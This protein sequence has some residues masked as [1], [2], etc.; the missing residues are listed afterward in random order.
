MIYK[1]SP[2]FKV[3]VDSQLEIS[4]ESLYK[5]FAFKNLNPEVTN[6]VTRLIDGAEEDSL[7]DLLLHNFGLLS[8]FYFYFEEFKKLG[9]LSI[10]VGTLDKVLVE[11]TPHTPD[12]CY[13]KNAFQQDQKFKLSRFCFFRSEGDHFILETPLCPVHIK[14]V[15][16]DALTIIYSFASPKSMI[17]VIQGNLN[18]APKIVEDLCQLLYQA[19]I[20]LTWDDHT[21]EEKDPHFIPWEFHD[22][23]FHSRSRKGRHSYAFGGTYPHQNSLPSPPAIKKTS[24]QIIVPLKIPDFEEA[25]KNSLP[26][27]FVLENRRSKR[28]GTH[29]LSS[30]EIS[31]FL[32]KSCRV[33]SIQ[34]TAMGEITVRPYPSAGGRYELEIYLVIH[35]CLEIPSGLYYYHPVNHHLEKISTSPE[36]VQSLIQASMRSAAKEEPPQVLFILSARFQRISWKYQSMAYASILK[37]VGSLMQTMYLVATSMNLHPCALGGGDSDFFAKACGLNYYEETSVGEFILS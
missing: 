8:Q 32:Y 4:I 24:S 22:L 20:I 27:S 31:E 23:L 26:F 12:F 36:N 6:V 5:T 21:E 29:G 35:N 13:Y 19:K 10:S 30:N 9:I 16:K 15:E 3:K 1:F 2:Y 28:E 11:A 14:V 33:K 18:F 37:D 25:N 17:E 34:Q 7:V